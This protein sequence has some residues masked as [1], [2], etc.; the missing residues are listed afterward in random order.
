MLQEGAHDMLLALRDLG[1]R[2]VLD[3]F[4]TGYSSL[5]YLSRFPIDGLKVDRSFVARMEQHSPEHA[6]IAAVGTMAESMHLD[7]VAEGI[8]TEAQRG[9]LTSLGYRLGQGFLF[10][11]P[12]SADAFL[13]LIA[14]VR[15]E[16]TFAAPES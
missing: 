6:I 9:A 7:V 1:V 3:D 12:T 16:P 10:S 5:S 2:V 11:K 13:A 14:P 15:T 8:E 4:G